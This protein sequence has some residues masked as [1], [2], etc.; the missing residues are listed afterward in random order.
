[1]ILAPFPWQLNWKMQLQL[2]MIARRKT[3]GF[4]E[5]LTHFPRQF[6]VAGHLGREKAD[7]EAAKGAQ[8]TP[9][10]GVLEVRVPVHR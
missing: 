1:M 10:R 9:I 8:A 6:R 7:T 5:L 4:S 2:Q 3:L